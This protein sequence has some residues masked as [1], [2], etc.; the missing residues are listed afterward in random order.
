[1]ASRLTQ[2]LLVFFFMATMHVAARNAVA[3]DPLVFIS[4]F[5]AGDQGAIH[6]YQLDLMTGI[7]KPAQRTTGVEHPFFLAL[8]PN[9]KFLY[10]IHRR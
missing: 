8:S 1:M 3:D 7:L 9:R 2:W 5:A 10:S 6:A 4:A